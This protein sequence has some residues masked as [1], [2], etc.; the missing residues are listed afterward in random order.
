MRIFAKETS[1][2]RKDKPMA[3]NAVTPVEAKS[4]KQRLN[5][6]KNGRSMAMPIIDT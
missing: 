4:R 3:T 6:K 1:I 5:T 2:I